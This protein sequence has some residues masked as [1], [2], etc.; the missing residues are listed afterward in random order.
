M[1]VAALQLGN[2]ARH[3]T[4]CVVLQVSGRFF[5][6]SLDPSSFGPRH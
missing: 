6:A 1:G 4:F 3:L 5:A 2:A